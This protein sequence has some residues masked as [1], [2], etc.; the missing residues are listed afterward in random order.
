VSDSAAPGRKRLGAFV[1]DFGDL[2]LGRVIVFMVT[3][4]GMAAIGEAMIVVWYETFVQPFQTVIVNGVQQLVVRTSN[5][6]PLGA[7][8][9]GLITV[10]FGLKG[11]QRMSEVKITS[12]GGG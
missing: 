9:S 11:W 8:G 1:D 3:L 12:G 5:G 2:S 4:M 6:L 10:A 7:F